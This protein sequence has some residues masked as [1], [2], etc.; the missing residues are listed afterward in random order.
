MP[1]QFMVFNGKIEIW[2]DNGK[3]VAEYNQWKKRYSCKAPDAVTAIINLFNEIIDDGLLSERN[4][5]K[6]FY[7]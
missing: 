1:K 2:E 4:G 3:F 5:H 6:D 7:A